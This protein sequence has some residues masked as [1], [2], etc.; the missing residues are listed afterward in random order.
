M[1]TTTEPNDQTTTCPPWCSSHHPIPGD[2]GDTLEHR[3]GTIAF[4]DKPFHVVELARLDPGPT[5]IYIQTDEH[6]L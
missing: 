5:G 6:Q 2:H 3:S 4:S 1:T